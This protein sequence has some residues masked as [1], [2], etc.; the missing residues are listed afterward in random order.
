MAIDGFFESVVVMNGDV[1]VE[2]LS[3]NKQ[4]IYLVTDDSW[5]DLNMSLA[6]EHNL[7]PTAHAD[8]TINHEVKFSTA[9]PYFVCGTNSD[10]IDIDPVKSFED[11][12]ADF[13]LHLHVIGLFGFI[14]VVAT[15]IFLKKKKD[16]TQW[17]DAYTESI[18]Q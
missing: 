9:P 14:V 7:I 18:H 2:E 13:D 8:N 4:D 6:K 15:S 5:N 12:D 11:S 17:G 1:V 10:C 16:K 3:P